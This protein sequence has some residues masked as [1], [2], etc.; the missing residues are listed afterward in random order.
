MNKNERQRAFQ[1]VDLYPVITSALCAGRDSQT[2]CEL[3]LAGGAR[4][5]QLR[6]KQMPSAELLLLAQAYRQLCSQAGALLIVNDDVDL[7]KA[8]AADGVHLGQKDMPVAEARVHAPELLIGVSTHNEE[9]ARRA[10]Q[11]GA[12][13]IN[14]GPIFPTQTKA[15]GYEF[16]GPERIPKIAAVTKLPFTVMGGIN[17][18]NLDQVLA[19]G[20]RRIAM[21]TGITQQ[22]DIEDT[23]Q[24][25]RKCINQFASPVS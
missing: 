23:V 2:V 7:A 1:D 14:I 17:A 19:Q 4:I 12:D 3:A 9:E 11:D 6:E 13:Y 25:L 15:T 8:S 10:E 22:E 21:V 24:K 18:S 16:L 20:A 5:V